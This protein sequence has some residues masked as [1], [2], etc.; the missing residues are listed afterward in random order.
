MCLGI[1]VQVIDISSPSTVRCSTG[2]ARGRLRDVQTALLDTPPAEGDWLLVYTGIAIRSLSEYEARQIGNAL[3]A[4]YAA[5][6]GEPFDHLIAEATDHD[7]EP[8]HPASRR[9]RLRPDAAGAGD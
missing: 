6:A 3:R 8:G 9:E 2:A 1:P 7:P 4:V 5:E